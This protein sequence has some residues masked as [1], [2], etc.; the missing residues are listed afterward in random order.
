LAT[1]F[2][3]HAPVRDAFLALWWTSAVKDSERAIAARAQALLDEMGLEDYRE[4]FVSELSTGVRRIVELA[5]ALAQRPD[6]LL[7]DEPAAGVAHQ[8]VEGLAELLRSLSDDT[9][10]AV[11]VIEHDVSLVADVADRLVCLHL[12]EVI[13]EGAPAEVLASAD[14]VSSFLGDAQPGV[15]GSTSR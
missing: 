9:G 11:L 3:L 10:M 12:G 8:E 6:V 7:L 2:E 5:C 13:A 4:R 1:A 15:L 14:V